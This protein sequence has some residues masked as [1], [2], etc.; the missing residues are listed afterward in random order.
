VLLVG[1][2]Q[3][4]VDKPQV[5]GEVNMSTKKDLN[6]LEVHMISPYLI[7]IKITCSCFLIYL[8]WENFVLLSI[9]ILLVL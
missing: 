6:I 7:V 9:W 8:Q 2:P 4:L 5:V 3:A 1:D